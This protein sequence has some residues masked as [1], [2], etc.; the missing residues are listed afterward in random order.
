MLTIPRDGLRPADL[1]V[2]SSTATVVTVPSAVEQPRR[3]VTIPCHFILLS[4]TSKSFANTLTASTD[5]PC[6]TT[7]APPPGCSNPRS[8]VWKRRRVRLGSDGIQQSFDTDLVECWQRV[9]RQRCDIQE[10]AGSCEQADAVDVASNPAPKMLTHGRDSASSRVVGHMAMVRPQDDLVV[11]ETCSR[12]INAF[13]AFSSSRVCCQVV[14]CSQS[15][16]WSRRLSGIRRSAATWR[17]V[18]P[19]NRQAKSLRSNS[20]SFRW[21]SGRRF[22]RPQPSARTNLALDDGCKSSHQAALGDVAL[23]WVQTIRGDRS[24][25]SERRRQGKFRRSTGLDVEA[26]EIE[27]PWRALDAS[28]YDNSSRIWVVFQSLNQAISCARVRRPSIPGEAR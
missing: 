3:T 6:A 17:Q 20:E 15:S 2:H 7:A 24:A 10:S 18:V 25:R 9:H 12:S 27:R 8:A 26:G 22:R 14:A 4:T 21:P 19:G 1:S 5:P 13:S 23:R 16:T 11:A 28:T